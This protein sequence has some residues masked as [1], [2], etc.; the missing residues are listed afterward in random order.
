METENTT[1]TTENTF[2]ETDEKAKSYI[3]A[4]INLS[5]D[6]EVEGYE[7]MQ[8]DDEQVL[9]VEIQ[10]KE[11]PINNYRHKEDY[12]LFITPDEAVS[13]TLVVNYE[14]KGIHIRFD[15]ETECIGNHY[16]GEGCSF[17]AH[18]EDVTFDGNKDLIISVGNSRHAEYYCAYIYENGEFRYEKTFEHIPSYE[19]NNDEKVIYG[20]DT[21]GVGLFIDTTYE[22]ID[23][24]FVQ[25][26]EKEYRNLD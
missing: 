20:S 11:S 19:I 14:D 3:D 16:L 1:R 24:A 17:A 26:E 15:E 23:G 7:W 21:D 25:I 2:T 10:Y 5:E 22:Y 12:F 8:Y 9:R 13:M 18:F 6:I 4:Y